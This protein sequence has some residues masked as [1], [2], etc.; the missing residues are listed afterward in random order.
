MTNLFLENNYL[1]IITHQ[2]FFINKKKKQTLK[3]FCYINKTKNMD[4]AK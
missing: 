4:N 1:K 2:I 3:T